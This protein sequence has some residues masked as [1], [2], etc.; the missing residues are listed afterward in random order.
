MS[1]TLLAAILLFLAS[2]HAQDKSVNGDCSA[3]PGAVCAEMNLKG[4]DFRGKNLA[5]TQFA[6]SEMSADELALAKGP[7]V[8]R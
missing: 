8:T 2:A 1:R 6:R 3:R 5:N 4:T 7:R